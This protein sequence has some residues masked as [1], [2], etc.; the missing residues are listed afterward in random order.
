M[1]ESKREWENECASVKRVLTRHETKVNTR[2]ERSTHG[3]CDDNNVGEGEAHGESC[4]GNNVGEGE[5]HG[6]PCDDNNVGEG[7]A[8]GEPCDGNNVGKR[9]YPL[10]KWVSRGMLVCAAK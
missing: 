7:E 5:A 4:D 6:E 8:N 10:W 2:V 9:A 3:S 1:S